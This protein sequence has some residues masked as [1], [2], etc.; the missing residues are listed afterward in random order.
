MG[1]TVTARPFYP[2]RAQGEDMTPECSQEVLEII[3]AAV[4]K[5]LA[6][7]NYEVQQQIPPLAVPRRLFAQGI[8]GAGMAAAR[9][10]NR[11]WQRCERHALRLT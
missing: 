6:M 10:W 11:G 2:K 7:E 1:R 9:A 4:D 3:T 5:H 8:R